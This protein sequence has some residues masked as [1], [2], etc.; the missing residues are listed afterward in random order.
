MK[1][2]VNLWGSKP[3]TDDDCW[4]GIDFD[5]QKDPEA[6]T[7]AAVAYWNPEKTDLVKFLD[8]GTGELWIEV[9][10]YGR[11]QMARKLRDA[12]PD[13]D[14]D[15]ADRQERAMQAGMGLGID[16]YNDANDEGSL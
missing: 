11:T 9:A 2:E 4:V 10:C 7:K 5:D 1:L 16:A 12:S 15:S 3:R 14:D 6:G 13:A 8:R